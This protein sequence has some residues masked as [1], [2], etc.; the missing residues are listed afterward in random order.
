[1]SYNAAS[2]SKRRAEKR[3]RIPPFAEGGHTP[4]MPNYRR[5]RVPGGTF[6]FTVNLLDRRSDLLVTRIDALRQAVG[7]C[8]PALPSTSTRG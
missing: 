6:F 1:M 4:C 5:N 2:S 8:A 3:E 7:K